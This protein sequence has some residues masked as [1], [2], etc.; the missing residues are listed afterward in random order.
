MGGPARRLTVINDRLRPRRILSLQRQLAEQTH[1]LQ[2]LQQRAAENEV[3]DGVG[4][5]RLREQQRPWHTMTHAMS[6]HAQT[7]HAN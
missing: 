2:L 4:R 7:Q 1:E 3:G 6:R 5:E